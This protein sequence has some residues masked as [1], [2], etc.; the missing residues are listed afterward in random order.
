V[1]RI[2]SPVLS[3]VKVS[4][5]AAGRA[6]VRELGRLSGREPVVLAGDSWSG[7]MPRALAVEGTYRGRRF[8]VSVPLQRQSLEAAEWAAALKPLARP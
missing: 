3:R 4:A 5:S 7:V 8:S 1:A 6:A 2:E